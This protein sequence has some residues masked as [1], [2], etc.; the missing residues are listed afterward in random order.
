MRDDY[1]FAL[2]VS[3][4]GLIVK[5]ASKITKNEKVEKLGKCKNTWKS[6]NHTEALKITQ[7][8]SKNHQL[9]ENVYV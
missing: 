5:S 2:A 1:I 8:S 6:Q 7:K 3:N 4:V 9:I